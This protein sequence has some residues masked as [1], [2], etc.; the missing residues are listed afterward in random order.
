[1]SGEG[2]FDTN[3]LVYALI[4]NDRRKEPARELLAAGGV[5]SVQVLNEFVAVARR[6]IR[7]SWDEVE[8][9]LREIQT[10]FP[11]PVALTRPMHDE[12]VRI[13]REYGFRIY[14]ALIAASALHANC[15]ELYTEDLQDG[16]IIDKRLSIRNPFR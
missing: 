8:A 16:Q 15:R 7:M 2:F 10:L 11:D 13:A 4:E 9:A 12:A 14:D 1:M 3:I 6:R 5:I